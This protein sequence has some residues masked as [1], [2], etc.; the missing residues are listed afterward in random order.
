LHTRTRIYRSRAVGIAV[1]NWVRN[2]NFIKKKLEDCKGIQGTVSLK[3]SLHK[4]I[5]GKKKGQK[6][7]WLCVLL[8]MDISYG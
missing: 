4:N 3:N 2:T 1:K 8:D 7:C 5:E 6:A